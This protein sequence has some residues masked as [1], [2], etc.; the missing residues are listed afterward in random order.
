MRYA[1]SPEAAADGECFRGTF[2]LGRQSIGDSGGLFAGCC[3]VLFTML[4]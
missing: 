4:R 3:S 1:I 2:R